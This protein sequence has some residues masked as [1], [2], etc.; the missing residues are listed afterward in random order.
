[1]SF[2]P[3]RGD[4]VGEHV[5]DWRRYE[6]LPVAVLLAL[7]FAF[8]LWPPLLNDAIQATLPGFLAGVP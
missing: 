8:G 6:A 7:C 5:H 4:A 3:L 2:G 1:M